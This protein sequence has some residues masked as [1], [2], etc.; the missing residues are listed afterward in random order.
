M[1]TPA[2]RLQHR[3]L[4]ILAAD[5]VGYS[6]AMSEDDVGTLAA[7]ETARAHFRASAQEHGG[8]VV[9]TAGDSVVAAFDTATGAVQAAAQVQ[10]RM[11]EAVLA[12]R[13][14]VHLGDVLVQPDGTLYGEGVNV[15]AR[16][17]ALA[18][19]GGV[20]V[21]GAVRAAVR[22][23]IAARLADRG[24]HRVK[25]IEH[26]VRAF[27]LRPDG[28][29][30][31][32]AAA[33]AADREIQGFGGRPALAVLPFDNLSNDPEQSYLADGIAED[34]LTRLALARWLP[35]I[36]RNS[37]F[38]YRG[39]NV[40]LKK[41][42][43]ELG[44]RYLVEGSVRKAG[45]R[46][47][48]TAQLIDATTAHH[49]WA[50]RYD[51]VLTDIFAVQDEIVQAILDALEASVDA[52]EISRVRGRSPRELGAWE[53]HHQ[54]LGHMARPD[55]EAFEQAIALFTEAAQR[56]PSFAAPTAMAAVA[57]YFCG[58]LG[59]RPVAETLAECRTLSLE[60]LRRDPE[61]PT[62]LATAAAIAVIAGQHAHARGFAAQGVAIDP[63]HA[64]GHYIL[65][66]VLMLEGDAAA[67]AAE[68]ETAL[69]LNPNDIFAPMML[70]SLSGAHYM[71]GDFTPAREVALVGVARA[72]EYPLNHRAL[73]NACGMLDQQEL[74][75][76]ALERFLELSPQYTE[77]V[78]RRTVPFAAP[79]D[80]DRYMEGLRRLGWPAA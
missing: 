71:K 80:F 29:G 11:A 76:A 63:S 58:M 49:V 69:R 41:V 2:S 15:A 48:I 57:L 67:S 5:A 19:T 54:A 42:G 72:P 23:E 18:D 44:A 61:H 16:L 20:L 31:D 13:V 78:A 50:Q 38:A 12:F 35:I 10:A 65:G 53:L 30:P 75:Q 17:Q 77:D 27:A 28:A 66:W 74:G 68:L 70:A 59:W 8:R 39:G 21:S 47:R 46:V 26:P 64:L 4:A 52:A 51:R 9:D 7:L 1:E 32:A 24:E 55:R 40:D 43:A 34:L 33:F 37:S 56:D 14:G 25:N 3:L 6:R 22:P 79:A 62:A 36:G 73:A 45:E 60:A